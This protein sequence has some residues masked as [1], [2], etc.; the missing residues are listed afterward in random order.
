MIFFKKFYQFSFCF[1]IIVTNF[2]QA[3][4]LDPYNRHF[5]IGGIAGYGSTTWNGL[6][7]NKENQNIAI[8]VSTPIAVDEGGA[9][10]GLVAGY[11]FIPAFAIEASYIHYPDT[12]V[13]FSAVSIYSF[14]HDGKEKFETKT[15]SISLM[16]KI[17][18]PLPNSNFR[19]FSSAGI[20]S[21]YRKDLIL[22]DWRLTPTFGAG[23][24]YNFTNRLFGEIAAN[25]TAGFAESQISPVDSYYP[26]IYSVTARI[27][28]R[29]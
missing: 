12:T 4:T 6:I 14:D 27:G 26:F 3:K 11:E 1:F 10:L 13:F 24:N 25:Y 19:L 22:D 8:T 9:S 16:G 28:F 29:I 7:A 21:L 15:D 2:C 17:L 23:V 20:A 18:L 5:Y